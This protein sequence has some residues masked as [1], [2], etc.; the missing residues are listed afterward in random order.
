MSSGSKIR[1][2]RKF[3][4]VSQS[5]LAKAIGITQKSP[6]ARIAQYEN[7]YYNPSTET[8]EQ[9]ADVLDVNAD[10]IKEHNPEE[11]TGAMRS[12]FELERFYGLTVDY[13]ENK[14]I[15]LRAKNTNQASYL[16]V[17][18]TIWQSVKDDLA[19]GNIT[20]EEYENWKINF[21]NYKIDPTKRLA[22][23]L[24]GLLEKIIE[25]SNNT[26]PF[27]LLEKNT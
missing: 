2:I 22:P 17:L 27:E 9:I 25:A 1:Y 12:L 23:E 13:D 6:H 4:K 20:Q 19:L 15:C 21:P 16:N 14:G 8:I 26:I 24:E 7:G 18:L 11:I 3:K 10:Y 5:T